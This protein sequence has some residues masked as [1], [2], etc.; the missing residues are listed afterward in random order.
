MGKIQNLI[1]AAALLAPV[2]VQA[3]EGFNSR[4]EVI[5]Q[6]SYWT[7]ERFADGRPKVADDI[8][9]KMRTVTLEE[10]WAPEIQ[11][12]YTQWLKD[13]AGRLAPYSRADV[14]QIID[15]RARPRP[16]Q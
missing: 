9:D 10:A 4:E 1:M 13:N 8:L 7:G 11:A 16:A 5:H 6:T 14:Q 12:D 3:H 2:A 15:E